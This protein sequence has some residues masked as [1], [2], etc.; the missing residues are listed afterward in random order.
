MVQSIRTNKIFIVGIAGGTGSGKTTLANDLANNL[1]NENVTILD[2]DAYYKDLSHMLRGQR[3][4][5]NF[6]HPDAVDIPLLESHI[7]AL[8]SG[9]AVNKPIYDYA[10]HSRT[11][12][13]THLPSRRVV[14]VEGILVLSLEEIHRHFDLK[15]FVEEA[16]DIRLI[17]RIHRD[18]NERGRNLE[19]ILQQYTE[20]VIPMFDA[21]VAP[22]RKHADMIVD[23]GKGAQK[24][25]HFIER[26]L[27]PW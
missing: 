2:A 15:I 4:Q 1:G 20:T 5:I 10:N 27:G 22:S 19:S 17:R 14:L 3:R 9:H 16:A 23:S 8:K 12:K 24:V 7:L 18:M 26:Q 6:D 11:G 13:T 25:I 21:F